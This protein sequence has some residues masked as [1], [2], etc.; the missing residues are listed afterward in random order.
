MSHLPRSLSEAWHPDGI[1]WQVEMDLDGLDLPASGREV[2]SI[3]SA[4]SFID[5]LRQETAGKLSSSRTAEGGGQLSRQRM[6]SGW[7]P[8][9]DTTLGSR[10]EFTHSYTCAPVRGME[11]GDP[12]GPLKT[13]STTYFFHD[14]ESPTVTTSPYLPPRV[15]GG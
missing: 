11:A 12:P 13:F 14:C 9:L 6:A 1:G 7:L 5:R 8:L 10:G 2:P 15:P 3:T 4:H